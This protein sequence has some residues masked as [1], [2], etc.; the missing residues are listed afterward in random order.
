[1]NCIPFVVVVDFKVFIISVMLVSKWS[2]MNGIPFGVAVGFIM[3]AV[4][5]ELIT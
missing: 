3:S 1:M 5:V 2:A 4:S